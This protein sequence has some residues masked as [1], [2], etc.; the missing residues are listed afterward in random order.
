MD[1]WTVAWIVWGVAF[2][3]I[4][5]GSVIVQHPGGTLSDHLRTLF[6]TRRRDAGWVLRRAALVVSLVV[7]GLHLF[8]LF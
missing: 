3:G 8:G 5:F 6:S 1:G 2:L 4:E 7:L